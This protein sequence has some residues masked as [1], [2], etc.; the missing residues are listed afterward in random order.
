MPRALA[1]A[2]SGSAALRRSRST[3]PLKRTFEADDAKL[4]DSLNLANKNTDNN[5]DNV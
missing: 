3:S 5:N 1:M 2:C 4:S